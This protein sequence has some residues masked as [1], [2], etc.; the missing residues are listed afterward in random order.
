MSFYLFCSPAWTLPLFPLSS[1]SI[2]IISIPCYAPPYPLLPSRLLPLPII[3]P[4]FPSDHHSPHRLTRWL[5]V[6]RS[7]LPLRPPLPTPTHP[8]AYSQ[9]FLTLLPLTDQTFFP[10]SIPKAIHVTSPLPLQLTIM[11]QSCRIPFLPYDH[12]KVIRHVCWI[13]L[14][15]EGWPEADYGGPSDICRPQ[16]GRNGFP[17]APSAVAAVEKANGE[18]AVRHISCVAFDPVFIFDAC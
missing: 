3:V 5:T 6:K 1:H 8:L 9:T 16:A 17:D 7:S 14:R 11:V 2:K 15:G 12:L 13:Y 10:I 18:S 4:L